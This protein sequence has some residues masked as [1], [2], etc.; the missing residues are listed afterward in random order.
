MKQV[1]QV[2]GVWRIP[3]LLNWFKYEFKLKTMEK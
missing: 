1:A 3:K 2:L